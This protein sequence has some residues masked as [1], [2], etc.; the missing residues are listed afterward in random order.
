MKMIWAV[1]RPE[2]AQRVITALDGVGIG[3]MT[4][5]HVTGH[6]RGMGITLG[7]VHYTEIPKE[8][9]MIVVPDNYVAKA[10]TIIRAEAKTG[11]KNTHKEGTT[12][13]GKIFITYVED[14]F[15]I[16]T[17]GKAGMKLKE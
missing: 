2:C 4:R 8:M 17:A 3:G 14:S 1:I 12:G 9:L 15:A 5:L 6:G 7:S 13:D 11:A 16:R 10:V